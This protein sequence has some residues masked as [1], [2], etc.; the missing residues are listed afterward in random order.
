MQPNLHKN[1]TACEILHFQLL[2]PPHYHNHA[3]IIIIYGSHALNV[4][5][6]ITNS[7]AK[8]NVLLIGGV[9]Q[10]NQMMVKSI[11]KAN[12]QHTSLQQHRQQVNVTKAT[13]Q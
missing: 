12:A 6:N 2:V 9:L 7:K 11:N 1:T 10:W 13:A 8:Y 5:V 3:R 4:N